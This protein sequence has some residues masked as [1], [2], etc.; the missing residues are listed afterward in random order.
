MQPA[1]EEEVGDPL[2]EDFKHLRRRIFH[3]HG[4]TSELPFWSQRAASL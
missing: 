4:E 2:L 1:Q 3:W